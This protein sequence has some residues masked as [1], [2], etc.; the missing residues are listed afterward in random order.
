MKIADALEA[1]RDDLATGEMPV[2][3]VEHRITLLADRARGAEPAALASSELRALPERLRAAVSSCL[4]REEVLGALE[5]AWPAVEADVRAAVEGEIADRIEAMATE[6]LSPE[7]EVPAAGELP[8]GWAAEVDQLD[9]DLDEAGALLAAAE[10]QAAGE[11][12]AEAEDAVRWAVR[13][14]ASKGL[15]IPALGPDPAPAERI[16][17]R[18][19]AAIKPLW[20]APPPPA[21]WEAI[22]RAVQEAVRRLHPCSCPDRTLPVEDRIGYDSNT[23]RVECHWGVGCS[24]EKGE[25]TEAA[26]LQALRSVELASA[27]EAER[28]AAALR[29]ML[30]L[31]LNHPTLVPVRWRSKALQEL[32]DIAKAA[33][34]APPS[35][36]WS[37]LMALLA[38]LETS[39]P[40]IA[41]DRP[42]D[43]EISDGERA[44]IHG[45]DFG[46]REERAAIGRRLRSDLGLPPKET[47]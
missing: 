25:A 41:R 35:D 15:A 22:E 11:L 44:Y 30:R 27:A 21:A 3:E 38:E 47:P 9:R 39:D 1:L 34:A 14:Y 24:A 12:P 6:D 40:F 46:V 19:V 28:L 18:V 26:V 31:C 7:L 23:G 32:S 2:E 42:L 20:P 29:E 36:P 10:E 16:A 17:N 5:A 45:R 4:T 8:A 37:A 13:W 43:P 33:L